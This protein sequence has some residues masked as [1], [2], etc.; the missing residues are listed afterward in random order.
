[1][2]V[3]SA[4][5][6]AIVI[7]QRWIVTIGG[8]CYSIYLYHYLVIKSTHAAERAAD[9]PGHPLALDLLLQAIVL[10]PPILILSAGLYVGVEKPCMQ[11]SRWVGRKTIAD[12]ASSGATPQPATTPY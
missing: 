1:M 12:Q 3:F 5:R 4:D 7:T 9:R 2:W 11:L 6:L 10:I 8:M